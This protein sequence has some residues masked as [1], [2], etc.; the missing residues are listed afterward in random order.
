MLKCHIAGVMKTLKFTSLFVSVFAIFNALAHGADDAA[1]DGVGQNAERRAD[2]HHFLARPR[3]AG[4]AQL[5]RGLVR[6]GVHHRQ[7]REAALAATALVVTVEEIVDALPRTPS[8]KIQKF[9]LREEA[10]K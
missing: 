2:R 7:E 10:R 6:V 1:R 5:E 4:D 8:G 9:K 3:G